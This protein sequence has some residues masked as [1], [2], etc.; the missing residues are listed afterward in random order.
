MVF[1]ALMV[2]LEQRDLE[3]QELKD[4]GFQEL[5]D[6]EFLVSLKLKVLE[7]QEL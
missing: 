4:L 3:Y 6:L 5:K 7:F 1:Q 2:F